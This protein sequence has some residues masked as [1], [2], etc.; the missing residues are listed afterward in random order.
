MYDTQQP[1]PEPSDSDSSEESPLASISPGEITVAIFCA[2]PLESVAVRYA[3]DEEFHCRPRYN[4]QTKYVFSYGRIGEH[5]VVLARPHQI[6]PVKAAL[7]AA[8]VGQLFPSVRFALMVG[9]G[10]GI[11]G[12]R[13]IRLGDVAV[14]V[15]RENHPGVVEYDLGKYEKDGFVL[16]GSLNKPHPILVSADGALEEEEIMERRPLRR[17]LRDLM[18]RP[19]YGRPDLE[20]VLYDPAFHH[21]TKGEDCRACDVADE[22]RVVARPVRP[23]KRGYPVVHRG[24]ILSGG[25][26][27]KNTEDRERL[28][29]GHD[30]AICFEMEA[31]GIVDEIPCL[32]IR[33]VCD[34]A[35]S[36]KQD[37]WHC[38]AAA[39][40]AAYGKAILRRICGADVE[41][42][43]N[44][45]DAVQRCLEYL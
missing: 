44:L 14:G 37:G 26:V 32:V 35:D 30:D 19:G 15:P 9:I 39:V 2:L 28:C 18:R 29:R 34:Y 43:Q 40:A 23:G 25:G 31:A 5:K 16:K 42:M 11:P 3:L 7:C 45:S 36:H 22:R 10:A 33:G 20:D 8:A 4:P 21:V 27:I 6:G 38:Y 13:D 1:H 41:T 12:K 24:L 17:V